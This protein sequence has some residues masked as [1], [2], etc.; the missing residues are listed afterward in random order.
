[1]LARLLV[2]VVALLAAAL[3]TAPAAAAPNKPFA[4]D[5]APTIEW[6]GV[7]DGAYSVTLT[8]Q[9]ATQELGSADIAIPTAFTVVGAPSSGAVTSGN[10]LQLRNLDLQPGGSVTVTLGLRMPCVAG[11]YSWGVEAKQSNDFSGPPGNALGPISG[12]RVTTVRGNCK[13]RFVDQPASA[14]KNA[15]IRADAFQPTSAHLVTVEAIDGSPSPQRLT[16]FTGTIDVRLVQSGPGKLTPS[17]ASSAATAG[18][19]SFGSL[20]ID[21]SGNYNLR[22]TT[23]A[24]GFSAGDSA[25]FQVIGVVERCRPSDCRAQIAGADTTST[26]LGTPTAGDG[27]ALLSLELG[28]VPVCAGYTPATGDF[29]EF[30]LSGVTADKTIV[31][32]FGRAAVKKAGGQSKLEICFAAPQAFGAKTGPAVPFDYDGDSANGDEGF[33][34][35]LPDCPRTPTGPCILGRGPTGG[36]G[37]ELRFFV[38]AA[39]GDPRYTG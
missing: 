1:M 36:S 8:N 26:L 9:T 11:D 15:Q 3:P 28:T 10:V 38:P 16:W 32:A 12:N 14:E 33:V 18:L 7:T 2:A 19:V 24:A 20:A 23:S 34:G 39:W 31:A 6:A 35:L 13:L 4:M 30:G 21:E 27:F 22:A 37:A 17:P 29:Y 25:T 5:V